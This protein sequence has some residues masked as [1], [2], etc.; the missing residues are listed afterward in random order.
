MLWLAT[1]EYVQN[2][3]GYFGGNAADKNNMSS[4]GKGLVQSVMNYPLFTQQDSLLGP[5]ISTGLSNA[6][7][8]LFQNANNPN[9]F[10]N[11][12]PLN[13]NGQI[14]MSTPDPPQ[15][16]QP[17]QPPLNNSFNQF[18]G[19]AGNFVQQDFD[20]AASSY[21]PASSTSHPAQNSRKRSLVSNGKALVRAATAPAE[22]MEAEL[23]AVFKRVL[24]SMDENKEGINEQELSKRLLKKLDNLKKMIIHKSKRRRTSNADISPNFPPASLIDPVKAVASTGSFSS[25]L[26]G[27][28]SKLKGEGLAGGAQ[29][30]VFPGSF[31]DENAGFHNAT[32]IPDVDFSEL[33]GQVEAGS[34]APVVV[35]CNMTHEGLYL[36]LNVNKK[37]LT[38]N[39]L[40]TA[41]KCLR[42]PAT[43]S[44]V[45]KTLQACDRN[46]DGKIS[47]SE[48]LE[49]L[50][51]REKELKRMFDQMDLTG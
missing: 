44:L 49:Y 4:V 11:T 2:N 27:I 42:I 46:G 41:Y 38:E 7:N 30:G 43:S 1:P 9:G 12:N 14:P 6:G 28:N 37:G 31:G 26:D 10:F 36:T 16:S 29:E 18:G 24:A 8:Q 51:E 39:E 13:A 20:Q 5:Q 32:D 35:G 23:E 3:T 33:L 40:K 15:A 22:T 45:K 34:V 47:M 21:F 17:T 25:Y 48:F 19:G 50:K